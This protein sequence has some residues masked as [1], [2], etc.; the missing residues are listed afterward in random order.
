MRVKWVPKAKAAEIHY[1][2]LVSA[3]TIRCSGTQGLFCELNYGLRP[4]LRLPGPH[5]E[6]YNPST[7]GDTWSMSACNDCRRA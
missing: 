5:S 2:L 7:G 4:A 3:G 6:G 1:S